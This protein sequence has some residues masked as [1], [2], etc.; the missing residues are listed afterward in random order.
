[1]AGEA[2]SLAAGEHASE[3]AVRADEQAPPRAVRVPSIHRVRDLGRRARWAALALAVALLAA[4]V[5]AFAHFVPGWGPTSDPARMGLRA[6]DVGTSRT[7]L[8]GQPSQSGLYADSV[9]S[10]HHPGPIHLYL[11]AAPVRVVGA[12]VGMPLVSVLITGSCLLV[13]AWVVHRLLGPPAALVAAAGLALVAVTTGAASLVNP[14]SS[15]IAGYPLLATA[16]L[17]WAVASG[18]VRL[19]PLATVAASFTAQ[20]HLSVVPATIVVCAG[21]LGLGVA[22]WRRDGRRHDARS[23]RDLRRAGVISAVLALVLWAPVLLQQALGDKGNLGQMLWFARHGNSE[24]VGLGSAM[25][26]LAHAVGLPP[27][28]GRTDAT[29]ALLLEPPS[30]LTWISAAAVLAAV[31]AVT[32]RTRRERARA[33]LGVMIGVVA[34]AGLVNG[35]S[36][37]DGLEKVRLAFYHWAFVLA[38]LVLVVLGSA[39]T[40]GVSAARAISR[41]TA[42][43]ALATVVILAVAAAGVVSPVLDR[44]QNTASAAYSGLPAGDLAD[45]ADGVLARRDE[46]G[47]HTV[48]LSRGETAFAEVSLGLALGLAQ[49]GVDVKLPLGERFFVNDDRLVARGEVDGG[50]VLVA[51]TL[52][53]GPT[54]AGGELVARVDFGYSGARAALDRLVEA[55]EAVG[56]VEFGP[57]TQAVLDDL[58]DDPLRRSIAERAVRSV[59]T[60]PERMLT[61]RSVLD[62]LESGPLASPQ[63]APD[64]LRTV[65]RALDRL[66]DDDVA[67][68]TTGLRVY[69]LDRDEI[70]DMATPGEIGEPGD[71]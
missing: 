33:T 28:V 57:D 14:V 27:L 22:L 58:G 38:F 54:P 69:L 36:V 12:A 21:G 70:L 40:D 1:V 55:A 46:L 42:R 64:D 47:D 67:G 18:D 8:L 68:N 43:A 52:T 71:G 32:V 29:G 31:A 60:E 35:S 4:P 66:A 11:L 61:R 56:E 5:A 50:L 13:V 25:R 15:N 9:A 6:L 41:P 37:P 23:R 39:V 63:L 30:L 59:A 53:P 26:Q 17:V 44:R 34:V 10:V 45:L 48:L 19:L 16:V 20:Q 7:P 49:Q 2:P 62:M 24:T 65:A 51:D 3:Q